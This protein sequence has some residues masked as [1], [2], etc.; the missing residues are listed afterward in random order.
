[1]K[2]H[3][4][5]MSGEKTCVLCGETKHV[6][7]FSVDKSHRDGLGSWCRECT[8]EQASKAYRR[9]SRL[10]GARGAKETKFLDPF[11]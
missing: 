11:L 8:A 4:P 2:Q 10:A 3:E 5:R 1:M 9:K 7:A 6:L